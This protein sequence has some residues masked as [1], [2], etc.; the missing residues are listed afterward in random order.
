MKDAKNI[1]LLDFQAELWCCT[2]FGPTWTILGHS[3]IQQ[4]RSQVLCD[5]PSKQPASH[6]N[7]Y[8][9]VHGGFSFEA[10]VDNCH[11]KSVLITLLFP[12]SGNVSGHAPAA[13]AK[14]SHTFS[15]HDCLS[16]CRR[17]RAA[18]QNCSPK[19]F[20]LCLLFFFFFFFYIPAGYFPWNTDTAHPHT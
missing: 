12:Q 14:E 19:W 9:W 18:C 1:K 3:L 10:N 13:A 4:P 17:Q 11:S 16:Q 6:F 2:G 5:L 8:T 15:Y 20:L 7:T